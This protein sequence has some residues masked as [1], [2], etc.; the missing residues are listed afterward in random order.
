[1]SSPTFLQKSLYLTSFY[2]WPQNDPIYKWSQMFSNLAQ[3]LK[4]QRFSATLHSIDFTLSVPQNICC[5]QCH[6]IVCSVSMGTSHWADKIAANIQYMV[7]NIIRQ[8]WKIVKQ[9]PLVKRCC[10]CLW[11]LE[12][13]LAG[14]NLRALFFKS[15]LMSHPFLV[16][17]MKEWLNNI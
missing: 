8:T 1:M 2:V 16:S 10:I 11:M 9:D 3:I 13:L 15:A 7:P 4:F 12:Y 14:F 6:V 17:K 5:K